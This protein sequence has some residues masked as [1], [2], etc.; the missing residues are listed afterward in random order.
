MSTLRE[1]RELE[2]KAAEMRKALDD[3]NKQ[4]NSFKQLPEGFNRDAAID[5]LKNPSWDNIDL[6]FIWNSTAQGH[7]HW[8][9]I[10]S[11]GEM[12]LEDRCQIQ[13]WIIMSYKQEFG[14]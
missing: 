2:A 12:T 5:S 8:E 10:A 6:A 4:I 14:P 7:D 13:E 3:V 11:V 9:D 1:L